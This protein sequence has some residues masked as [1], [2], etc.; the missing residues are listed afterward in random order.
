MDSLESTKDAL[1]EADKSSREALK[2]LRE[3]VGLNVLKPA[4]ARH[5][6]DLLNLVHSYTQD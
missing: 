5:Y 1:R 2:R 3:Q 4:K 6:V